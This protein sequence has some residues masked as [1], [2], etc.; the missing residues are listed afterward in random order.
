MQGRDDDS[1]RRVRARTHARA[2]AKRLPGAPGDGE[3]GV[4]SRREA[5][6][7]SEAPRKS[8]GSCGFFDGALRANRPAEAIETRYP[9]SP[10]SGGI[11]P[12]L[13]SLVPLRLGDVGVRNGGTE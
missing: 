1:L 9:L 7:A 8:T 4:P 11:P 13:A 3:R 2:A 10:G 12:Q 6:D 5:E